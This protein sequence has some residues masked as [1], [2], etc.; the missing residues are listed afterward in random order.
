MCIYSE[1]LLL[2][3]VS[4]TVAVH[5]DSPAPHPGWNNSLNTHAH[6]LSF[7][8]VNACTLFILH[9][10]HSHSTFPSL[11]YCCFSPALPGNARLN[12]VAALLRSL[13][14]LPAFT[15]LKIHLLPYPPTVCAFYD[16]LGHLPP[17]LCCCYPFIPPGP[18]VF[19]SN[20]A[21]FETSKCQQHVFHTCTHTY[22]KYQSKPQEEPLRLWSCR[23]MLPSAG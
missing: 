20:M 5:L 6:T 17:S 7:L 10:V 12:Q 11:L 16:L 21:I 2:E 19:L 9:W 8:A 18:P 14:V 23:T 13:P 15:L 4:C 22:S 1:C 3:Q